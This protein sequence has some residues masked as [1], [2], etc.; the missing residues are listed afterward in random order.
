[1]TEERSGV[2]AEKLSK[3][4]QK[5]T[6]S[7]PGGDLDV[8]K[9]R[10]FHGLLKELFPKLAKE[11]LWEDFDGALL[12]H[13]KRP[14]SLR[15]P[16][17]F[18]NHHDVVEANGIW[19]HEPFS[20]DIAEGKVWGRGTLDTKGGLFAMLQAAEELLESGAKFNRDIYFVSSCNEETTG[21]GAKKISET[22]KE[23]KVFAEI[24]FDEG[25]MVV[26]EPLTGV[27][28]TFAMVSL[29][30]KGCCDIRFAARSKGGHSSSPRKNEALVRLGRFMA[31][32]DRKVIFKREISP[33][34]DGMFRALAPHI[35]G[36]SFVLGHPGLFSGLLKLAAPYIS[37]LIQAMMQ[38]TLCFTMAEGSNGTNVL[39]TEAAV[40]GNMRCS[41]HE[42]MEESLKKLIPFAKKYNVEIDVVDPAIKTRLMAPD[43][44]AFKLVEKAVKEAVPAADKSIPYIVTGTTD[45][46]YFDDI[47]EETIRFLPLR[48][49]LEQIDSIHGRN[50]CVDIESLAPAVDFYK[51]LMQNG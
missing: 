4:I 50:E 14:G 34:L 12:I 24:T 22:L 9:F 18:M 21:K 49:K 32:A 27:K 46:R 17:I 3:M 29:G 7:T 41:H 26:D 2:Y 8:T 15:A 16:F 6:I 33:V 23:R 10:E 45:A 31:D 11:A 51:Y 20:G 39:P 38:T 13:I 1:M 28:G 25:G 47:S 40:I 36:L 43:G 35:K 42:G 19:K 48:V 5:E 37:P 30:E 44:K